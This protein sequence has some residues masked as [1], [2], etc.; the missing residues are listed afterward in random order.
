MTSMFTTYTA[1]I[2]R[3]RSERGNPE[4]N[5][6]I[7]D[8][9]VSLSGFLAMTMVKIKN[10]VISVVSALKNHIVI[11]SPRLREDR[12][13]KDL[14]GLI[15]RLALAP[16]RMATINKPP[17]PLSH[18]EQ[19]EMGCFINKN[20]ALQ[21]I[22]NLQNDFIGISPHIRYKNRLRLNESTQHA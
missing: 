19:K 17:H 22:N 2:A 12:L 20:N 3:E 5:E 14:K 8:C 18:T 10:S 1:V 9:R 16:A 15:C 7:L 13:A 4:L 6:N 21:I 11:L